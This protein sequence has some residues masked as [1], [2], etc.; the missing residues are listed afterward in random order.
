LNIRISKAIGED[1]RSEWDVRYPRKGR[2]TA[3]LILLVDD[4]CKIRCISSAITLGCNMERLGGISR[5]AGEKELQEG[6]Y[7]L[8]CNRTVVNGG[9]VVGVRESDIDW[10]IKE[11]DVGATIPT[12]WVKRGIQAILRNVAWSKFKEETRGGTATGTSIEPKDQ[13]YI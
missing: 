10:L 12:M 1:N 7:I 4:A 5:K 3:F 11:Y 13:R 8:A 9:A 6:I 2:K